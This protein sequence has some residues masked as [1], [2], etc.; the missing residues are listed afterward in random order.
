[1]S[2]VAGI[3]RLFPGYF[4]LCELFIRDFPQ[5]LIAW[6]RNSKETQSNLMGYMKSFAILV[7]VAFC[8]EIYGFDSSILRLCSILWVGGCLLYSWEDD[9]Q[10]LHNGNKNGI[11][12]LCNSNWISKMLRIL[13]VNTRRRSIVASQWPFSYFHLFSLVTE[14]SLNWSAEI[15]AFP[16]SAFPPCYPRSAPQGRKFWRYLT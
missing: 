13:I 2:G 12:Q 6:V 5:I 1:M 10:P 4:R 16:P 14:L 3:S 15:R 7:S 8:L 9:S 11:Y